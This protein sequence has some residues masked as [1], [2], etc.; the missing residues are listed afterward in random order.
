MKFQPEVVRDILLDIEELHQ[1][2]NP[3]TFSTPE[4]FNRAKKYDIDTIAY[5]C[6][7]LEEAKFLKWDP[8]Y[9]NNE[10]QNGIINGITYNGHQFLDSIRSPKVWRETKARTEK[11]G[12]FTINVI[13]QIASNVI[14]D[15]IKR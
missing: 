9:G 7:L 5:H 14:S 13:S 6:N 1:Y 12:I 3:F 15:M 8:I 10:L 11:L 4:K 2:P